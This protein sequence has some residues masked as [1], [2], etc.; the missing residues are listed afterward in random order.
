[1]P[2]PL[3]SDVLRERPEGNGSIGPLSVFPV[4]ISSASASKVALIVGHG[5]RDEAANKEFED[6]VADFRTRYHDAEVAHC[7]VELARPF[8][9]DALEYW[10]ERASEVVVAPLFLFAAGHTK[11]DI[12]VAISGAR[13]KYPHVRF[14][15]ARALGVHPSLIEIVNERCQAAQREDSDQSRTAVV[16]VGRGSSDPDANGDFCK[17]VRLLGEG[18][19]FSWITPSFIGVT[20]PLFKET[21]DLVAR[22]RPERILVIPYFLFGGRLLH[23]L[24]SQVQDFSSR[25]PWIRVEVSAPIGIHTKLLELMKERVQ[26]AREERAPLPCDTCQYRVPIAG[27]TAQVGGLKSLL[28]SIRH[29]LTHN[30]AM[31]HIHAHVPLRKHVLVCTN[32]DCAARGSIALLAI[33]RRLLKKAGKTRE[34]R[35]TRTMCMGRCGEGPTVAVYPDG[36]WYRGVQAKDAEDLVHEHLLNDRLVARLVDNVMQ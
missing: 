18:N 12:P 23:Q 28:W 4:S 13:V 16:V 19:K 22:S 6:L 11:N 3:Q 10:A 20:R 24:E 26:E 36:V 21:I 7:Y 25:Y 33:L 31:P 35:V 5:S 29:M 27:V 15:V 8:L 9:S 32:I 14:R 2:D 17:V 30:S 1:M 34:I